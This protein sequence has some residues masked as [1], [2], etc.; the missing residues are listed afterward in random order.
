MVIKW[1]MKIDSVLCA[2]LKAIVCTLM[3]LV[4]CILF[5]SV[6]FRYFLNNP[7]NWADEM[8][9]YML[10]AITFL[11]AYLVLRQNKMV[12]VTFVI[13]LF[14]KKVVKI[15]SVFTNL[16]ITA[17]LGLIYYQGTQMLQERIVKIQR[18]VALQIPMSIPYSLIPVMAVLLIFGMIIETIKLI[19]PEKV[20]LY[21]NAKLEGSAE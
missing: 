20:A 7:I 5:A 9:T 12:K 4:M 16:I 18:T 1:I 11:G 19:A 15:V 6:I 2:V 13:D 10:V 8:V 14:P 17:L 21:E 3:I